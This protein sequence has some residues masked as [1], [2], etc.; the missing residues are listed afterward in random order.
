M[1][2]LYPRLP[3]KCHACDTW[4]HNPKTC[5]RNKVDQEGKQ[6]SLEDGEINE[7]QNEE[8]G[9]ESEANQETKGVEQSEILEKGSSSVEIT[10]VEKSKKEE[11][12]AI[13][14]TLIEET[15]E[16][17][18]EKTLLKEN[19]WLDVSPDKAS[20]SPIRKE[21]EFGQVSLLKNSRFSVL[22]PT[23]DQEEENNE[24]ER[25]EEIDEISKET[26]GVIPRQKLPRESKMNHRYLKDRPGQK[27]QDVD[28]SYLNKKKPHR[29]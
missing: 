2:Y 22:T 26:E 14:V 7:K 10:E 6:E 13:G 21:L 12:V 17:N 25:E 8:K 24:N 9:I 20:R 4:G 3:I 11:V 28:P 18:T 15:N 1:E 27:A 29:Q 5:L 16:G 19:E 23:E